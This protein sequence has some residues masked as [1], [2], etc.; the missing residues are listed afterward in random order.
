MRC[1]RCH[2]G[3]AAP[4]VTCAGC[5]IVQAQFLAGTL[6][7]LAS[8]EIPADPMAGSVECRDCH[9]LSRPANVE[10]INEACM[11]CHDDEAERFE[12]MLQSWKLQVERLLKEARDQVDGSGTP[13]IEA[14]L[15]AGPLHNI[16]AARQVL[17]GLAG[18]G[19]QREH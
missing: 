1:D 5:H 10:T 18:K 15:E 8:F 2:T 9:D 4:A 17:S 19:E 16:E 12:G 13:A 11:E 14:L 7:A 3:G 6:S